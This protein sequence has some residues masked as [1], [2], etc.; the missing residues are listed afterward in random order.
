MKRFHIAIGVADVAS[1]IDDYTARLDVLPCVVVP[2]E[3]ALWRTKTLNLSIRRVGEPGALRHLG[4]ED[5]SAPSFSK[6]TDANGIIW[7][8]FNA[9]QQEREILD[10]WPDA[11]L[12]GDRD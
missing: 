6:D 12:L 9:E 2:G 5:P 3:Y 1:S 8:R 4:W 7:E 10:T 11:E